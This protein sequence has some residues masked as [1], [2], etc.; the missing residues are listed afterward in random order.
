MWFVVAVLFLRNVL[1][2]VAFRAVFPPAGPRALAHS[3]TSLQ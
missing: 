2:I 1:L 3:T